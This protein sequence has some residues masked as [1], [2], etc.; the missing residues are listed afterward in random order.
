MPI[1]KDSPDY[2]NYAFQISVSKCGESESKGSYTFHFGWGDLRF[3]NNNIT[4]NKC[5]KWSSIDSTLNEKSGYC[6]YSTFRE[7]NQTGGDSLRFWSNDDSLIQTVSYCNVIGNKCG[8]NGDQV[9]FFCNCNTNVD[10]CVFLNNTAKYMFTIYYSGCTLTITD[11]YVE[12][13]STTSTGPG[14]VTF[15]KENSNSDLNQLSHF[16]PEFCFIEPKQMTFILPYISKFA[17]TSSKIL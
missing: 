1:L 6:N 9:L 5:S 7:N 3:L 4:Y 12:I 10:H 15:T 8:T 16:Y 13:K 17:E 14:T 11:S 2:K